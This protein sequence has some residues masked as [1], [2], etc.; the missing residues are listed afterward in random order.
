MNTG[1]GKIL[2]LSASA[3]IGHTRAAEALKSAFIMEKPGCEVTI[4]DT[5]K[6]ANPFFEKLILGTYMEM[7][8]L[9]PSLYGYLYSSSEKGRPLS[10]FAKEAFNR[11]LSRFSSSR[12]LELIDRMSPEAVICTHPFTIGV[13][14]EI[15]KSRGFNYFTVG[16]IT[17]LTIHPYMVFP[18][19]DLYLVGTED[20]K[21]DLKGFGIQPDKIHATG[22]PIDPVFG[23]PADRKSVLESYSLD[24]RLTTILVM[25]GGLG[26]GPLADS[27][28]ELGNSAN[29]CQVIVVTGKNT[30]LKEKLERITP[31][32]KNPVRVLGYV[33]NIHQ[34]MASSNLMVGK[35]G[36]LS[37]SE[38]LS[39]GLPIFLV[40]PLPGQE[41]RNSSYLASTG[42][43]VAL[44][45][46]GDLGNT[47]AKYLE[48]PGR[49]KA[50][51]DAAALLGRPDSALLAARKIL[52]RVIAG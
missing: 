34:L 23:K 45:G 38:A 46:V 17:D 28:K 14:A 20:L 6:Y 24:D 1:S 42:A 48:N 35:A 39:Y 5:F 51:S 44:P 40:E 30:R 7:L 2:I 33:N 8:R 10:G 9:A 52:S 31:D 36:G 3:G 37:C 50:M 47:I 18:E 41:Q 32:L 49:M 22:I 21:E 27:V 25:G 16:V 29:H 12:L 43:A 13:L 11:L 15:R 19:V 26:L 4:L